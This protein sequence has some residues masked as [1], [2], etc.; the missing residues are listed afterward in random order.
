MDQ[1]QA[2][3]QRREEIQVVGEIDKA[4][5]G[6]YLAAEPDDKNLAAEGMDVGRDGLKPVDEPVLG[7]QSL[8]TRRRCGRVGRRLATAL[9]CV[10]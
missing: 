8:A 6:D 2:H 9:L 3:A 7:G 10:V 5:I 4:A 1:H